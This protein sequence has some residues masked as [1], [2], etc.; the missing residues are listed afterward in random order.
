MDKQN[1]SLTTLLH[2]LSK[3]ENDAIKARALIQK[4]Y[5]D[6]GISIAEAAAPKQASADTTEENENIKVIEGNFDGN[7]MQ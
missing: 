3:I 5:G 7:F 2:L 4:M 6:Q 1:E